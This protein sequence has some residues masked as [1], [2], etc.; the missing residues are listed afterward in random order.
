[1]AD[2]EYNLRVLFNELNPSDWMLGQNVGDIPDLRKGVGIIDHKLIEPILQH[3][4]KQMPTG[5]ILRIRTNILF[6]PNLNQ[7]T[8][9]LDV[10]LDLVLEQTK[11]LIP[12]RMH[13]QQF[14]SFVKTELEFLL[15]CVVV[16]VVDYCVAA[17]VVCLEGD[18][19]I[20]A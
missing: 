1:M 3:S 6:V 10:E 12:Q 8:F 7:L 9:N 18:Y 16:R 13:A 20:Q 14:W 11:K 15:Y 19:T 5:H 17:Q 4:H 2:M